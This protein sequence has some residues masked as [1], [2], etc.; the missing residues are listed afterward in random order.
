MNIDKRAITNIERTNEKIAK[1]LS[2]I[3]DIQEE[4]LSLVLE[5]IKN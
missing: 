1:I 4:E 3:E 5:E 2:K